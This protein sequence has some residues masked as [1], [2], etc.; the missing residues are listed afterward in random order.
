MTQPLD[1][2]L[3]T[4]DSLANKLRLQKF[5]KKQILKYKNAAVNRERLKI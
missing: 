4:F 1:I 5:D 3:E 2:L